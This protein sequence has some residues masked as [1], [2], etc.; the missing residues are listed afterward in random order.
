MDVLKVFLARLARRGW[1]SS[2]KLTVVP[3]T[4]MFSQTSFQSVSWLEPGVRDFNL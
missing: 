1:A 4:V 3:E 2:D